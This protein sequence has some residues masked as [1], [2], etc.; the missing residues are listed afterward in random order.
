MSSIVFRVGIDRGWSSYPCGACGHHIVTDEEVEETASHSCW[1]DKLYDDGFACTCPAYFHR[2]EFSYSEDCDSTHLKIE[3][4]IEN[5]GAR[6]TVVRTADSVEFDFTPSTD[7]SDIAIFAP[8]IPLLKMVFTSRKFN[9]ALTDVVGRMRAK[10]LTVADGI[11]MLRA[12][13]GELTTT[14]ISKFSAKSTNL[15]REIR[16]ITPM[17]KTLAR[18]IM[19]AGGAALDIKEDKGCAHVDAKRRC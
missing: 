19:A 11:T 8:H 4:H 13:S 14:I 2:F 10:R 9:A 7:D 16:W 3:T 15:R 18:A 6:R 17:A 12:L 5:K 1:C